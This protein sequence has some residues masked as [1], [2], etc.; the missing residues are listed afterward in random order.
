[1][2]DSRKKLKKGQTKGVPATDQ[3]KL[4][5]HANKKLLLP[6]ITLACTCRCCEVCHLNKGRKES[7]TTGRKSRYRYYGF[8]S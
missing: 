8:S 6:T 1:M 2:H 3:T 7:D 4:L 5:R